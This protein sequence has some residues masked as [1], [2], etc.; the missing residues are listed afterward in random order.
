[1]VRSSICCG[2]GAIKYIIPQAKDA[3]EAYETALWQ[4]PDVRPGEDKPVIIWMKY[5]SIPYMGQYVHDS[6][7]SI[8]GI[9]G[10]ADDDDIKCW[11][12][13]PLPDNGTKRF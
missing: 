4:K 5:N 2:C 10:Y 9:A 8:W 6:G 12:P 1:M 13:L 11:R 7:W 3:I